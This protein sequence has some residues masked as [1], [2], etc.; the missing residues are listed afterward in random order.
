MDGASESN[1]LRDFFEQY[2][3]KKVTTPEV[4][5]KFVANTGFQP[6]RFLKDEV[7]LAHQMEL[8]KAVFP[9]ETGVLL[10][11]FPG[12]EPKV[13]LKQDNEVSSQSEFSRFAEGSKWR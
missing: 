11:P 9:F 6:D 5:N 4:V 13:R 8:I 1:D 10:L 7:G 3:K 2:T 12:S